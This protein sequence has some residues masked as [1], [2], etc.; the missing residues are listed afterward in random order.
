GAAFAGSAGE[1]DVFP[2]SRQGKPIVY[3][4]DF[5]PGYGTYDNHGNIFADGSVN[6]G[7]FVF[8]ELAK[9][10]KS[11]APVRLDKPAV[12]PGSVEWDGKYVVV[13]VGYLSEGPALY[14]VRV[15]GYRG[16]VVQSVHLQQLASPARFWIHD[17]DVVAS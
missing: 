7:D 16:R 17:G 1:V 4:T 13:G 6:S 3:H 10:S 11:F 15:S 9:G 8:D 2:G 14:R 5:Q 12:N